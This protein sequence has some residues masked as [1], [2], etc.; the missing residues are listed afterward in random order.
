MAYFLLVIEELIAHPPA[1][2]HLEYLRL[3][4]RRMA[5]VNVA[6]AEVQKNT[7]PDDR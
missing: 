5:E 2:G 4:L 1:D 7:F 3:K 6:P